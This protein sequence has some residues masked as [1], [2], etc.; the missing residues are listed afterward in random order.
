[1]GPVVVISTLGVLRA[2]H[3]STP[4]THGVPVS[5]MHSYAR[6]GI[7]APVVVLSAVDRAP[8]GTVDA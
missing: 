8:A 5:F 3:F 6:V 7:V 2:L 1:M 4:V